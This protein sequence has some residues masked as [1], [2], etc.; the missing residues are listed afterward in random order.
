MA[1]KLQQTYCSLNLRY[2]IGSLAIMMIDNNNNDHTNNDNVT[3][4]RKCQFSIALVS[5][6]DKSP[7]SKTLVISE[8]SKH[9]LTPDQIPY[10]KVSNRIMNM[11]H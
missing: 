10:D 11:Q 8:N 2:F 3:N 5:N 4:D 7:C 9:Q 6:N 1:R